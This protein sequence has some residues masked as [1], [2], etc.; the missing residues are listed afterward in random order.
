MAQEIAVCLNDSGVTSSIYDASA[1]VIYQKRQGGW[2]VVRERTVF[3][4]KQAG[5][6]GL[7]KQMAELLPFLDSCR[8]FVGWSVVGVPYFELEKMQCS[9]WEFE[10]EP[11]S[12]L[13]YVLEKEEEK[14]NES[15]SQG[16]VIIPIPVERKKGDYYISIKDIQE[17]GGGITSKQ[18]LLPFL[19]RGK[20]YSLEVVCN[21]IP[22]WLQVELD[23][24][25]LTGRVEKVAPTQIHIYIRKKVCDES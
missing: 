11:L 6:A 24:G 5:M 25:S 9:I 17:N 21:H 19:H 23:G 18:V 4:D 13:D 16:K 7:R 20:F 8:I 12:F 1:L 22:P 10:G 3:L 2:K 14:I 15:Q